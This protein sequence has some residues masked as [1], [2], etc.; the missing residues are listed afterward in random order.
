MLF[1]RKE[2]CRESGERIQCDWTTSKTID[3]VEAVHMFI[4]EHRQKGFLI[5]DIGVFDVDGGNMEHR[6]GK[7]YDMVS[8]QHTSSVEVV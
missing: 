5:P 2:L 4:D 6:V 1:I 8:I 7:L 3:P